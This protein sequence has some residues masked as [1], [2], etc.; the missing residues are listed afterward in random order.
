MPVTE[1]APDDKRARK[2]FVRLE[3]ELLRDEPLFVPEIDSDVDKRIRGRSPFYEEMDRAWFLAG[4]GRD[5]A[6]CAALRNRRWQRDKEDRAGFIGYFAAAP[7]AGAEVAEMLGAAE[8]WL[9]E[10]G[11]DRAIAPHNGAVFHGMCLL[12]EAYDEDPVFPMPWQ[13]PH[14]RTLLEG[15]G[16]RPAYPFWVYDV[17]FSSERYR[18][19]S[20][21]ALEDTRCEVRPLDKKRWDEEV[22][23]LRSVFNDTFR[24]EWEFHAMTSEE[25]RE[26]FDQFKP[27]LDPTLLLFAE[28]DGEIA[29]FCN[30][31]PDWAPLFRSFGG[32]LGPLQ[33]LRLLLRARRYDRAGL[34]SIGVRDSYRGRHIGQTLAATLFRRYEERGLRRSYYYV[35]NDHNLNSRRLAE[36]LGGQGRILYHAYDKPLESA[37]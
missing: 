24:T 3:R 21:A 15:A 6:R 23:Q 1:L 32:K 2:R 19:A 9:A 8:R 26:L 28:V 31:M 18:T 10:R 4:D 11:C 34:L 17:D 35:V 22:E 7:G 36:S 13:P 25:F 33:I 27:V 20:R 12:T 5:R 30:G 16:Y 14:Y 37:G 29:G